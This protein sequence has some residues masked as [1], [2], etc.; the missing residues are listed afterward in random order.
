MKTKNV[1]PRATSYVIFFVT[2]SP[3]L[4]LNFKLF[5][6]KNVTDITD[7]ILAAINMF[8]DHLSIKNMRAENFKYLTNT[9]EIEYRKTIKGMN[10]HKTGQLKDIPSKIIKISVH[11]FANF[12]CLHFDCCIDIGEFPQIF[13][14]PQKIPVQ[15]KK[16]INE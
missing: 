10:V 7:P 3:I 15:K 2:T 11:V 12:I 9:K 5:L 8:Q 1:C 14:H 4:F 6:S 13:K 16:V